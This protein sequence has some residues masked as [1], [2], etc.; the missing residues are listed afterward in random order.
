MLGSNIV[1][2]LLSRQ[3]EVSVFVLPN[4]PVL[5]PELPLE[6]ITGNI[7]ELASLKAA[8]EGKDAMIHVAALTDV[9]PY[10]SEIVRRVNIEGTK[11]VAAATL[12]AGLKRLVAIGSASS[13][14]IGTKE[15][16]G[17]EETTFVSHKYGLD[18]IDSKKAAQDYLLQ[19]A[20]EEALPVLMVNPTFMFGPYDSK[21]G[22]GQMI[23]AIHKGKVPGY[24][25]GGRNYIS[26]KDVAVAAVNGLTMGRTGEAYIAGNE[27]LDYSEAFQKIGEVIGA[28]APS[29]KIPPV[30]TK[31][32]G[33]AS[34][35]VANLLGTTPTISY[36]MAVIS[37]DHHYFSSAKA[38]KELGLPQT[39]IKIAIKECFDWMKAN[40]V[41]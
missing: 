1:K 12:H 10:R 15:N 13:C 30:L 37:S 39:D 34:A 28:K 14:G 17:T 2:E 36:P 5:F 11:N 9:W 40:G 25:S 4:S 18:Y 22:A 20:K 32:I 7:L 16:P 21:P 8:A 19:A 3:H 31:T 33:W 35:A 41:C 26:A 29:W 23:A 38:I 24:T 27:N 6:R